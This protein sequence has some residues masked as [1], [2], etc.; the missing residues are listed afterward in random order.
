MRLAQVTVNGWSDI[1]RREID[2]EKYN[3]TRCVY[4]YFIRIKCIYINSDVDVFSS[5]FTS[6]Y[7]T[8]INLTQ[9]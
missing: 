6:I 9:K 1:Y 5:T 7:H 2:E 8:L 3:K 4:T